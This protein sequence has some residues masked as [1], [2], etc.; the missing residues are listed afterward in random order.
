MRHRSGK[1]RYQT[2]MKQVF[3]TRLEL[4]II[5]EIRHSFYEKVEEIF[6]NAINPAD[7]QVSVPCVMIPRMSAKSDCFLRSLF[8]DRDDMSLERKTIHISQKSPRSL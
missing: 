1:E 5:N 7:M 6:A 3:F 2:Q 4:Y 8:E